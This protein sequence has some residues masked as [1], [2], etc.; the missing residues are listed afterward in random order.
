MDFLKDFFMLRW[1]LA[2]WAIP[3]IWTLYVLHQAY[4][5]ISFIYPRNLATNYPPL[6]AL[7]Q[8]IAIFLETN[9]LIIVTILAPPILYVSILGVI[10]FAIQNQIF[11]KNR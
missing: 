7:W 11:G 3:L 9:L 6:G 1:K 5:I 8:D 2:P 4:Y 10:L